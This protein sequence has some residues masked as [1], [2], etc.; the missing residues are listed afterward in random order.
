MLLLD[1]PDTMFSTMDDR[2]PDNAEDWICTAMAWSKKAAFCRNCAHIATLSG[3]SSMTKAS[4][5]RP[6]TL[7]HRRRTQAVAQQF[8]RIDDAARQRLGR[9]RA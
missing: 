9:Q 6:E 3:W 7:H 4:S 8:Y 5:S 2:K 1:W